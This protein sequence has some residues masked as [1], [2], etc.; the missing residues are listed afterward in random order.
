VTRNI[1]ERHQ[2]NDLPSSTCRFV[3]D[4]HRIFAAYKAIGLNSDEM[5]Q[6]VIV[7]SVPA[8]P[9]SAGRIIGP[10]SPETHSGHILR[11]A[12]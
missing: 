4:Q 7:G 10:I 8:A 12:L 2:P 9:P 3:D 11:R 6:L 1:A 5:L